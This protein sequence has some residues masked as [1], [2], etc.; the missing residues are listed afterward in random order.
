MF[1]TSLQYVSFLP[2]FC[3]SE[4]ILS[5]GGRSFGW[6]KNKQLTF[7]KPTWKWRITIVNIYIY[8]YI[9]FKRLFFPLSCC[10]SGGCTS[11]GWHPSVS[12]GKN[13]KKHATRA[14]LTTSHD[15]LASSLQVL[16]RWKI[17]WPNE[18]QQPGVRGVKKSP[19]RKLQDGT[20]GG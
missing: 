15:S 13:N 14:P 1:T 17:S 11:N 18:P 8:G 20:P 16:W 9:I 7:R 4:I 12:T 3:L 19:Y 5:N 10:F 2:W 6:P